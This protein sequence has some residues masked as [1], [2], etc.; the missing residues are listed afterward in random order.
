MRIEQ[1]EYVVAVTRHGSLRKAGERLHVSQPAL[2]EA[3][4][5]LERELGVVL[6]DRCRSGS[7]I[8]SQGRELLPTMVEVLE[9][10]ERLRRSAGDQTAR[11]R[12]L[13]VGTAGGATSTVLVPALKA[14][15][16]QHPGSGVEVLPVPQDEIRPALVD[17]GLDLGLVHA[18]HGDAV[19]ADLV[20]TDLLHGRAVVVLPAGHH[21]TAREAVTVAD[22]RHERT[23]LLGPGHP[24]HR[25]T[26]RLLGPDLP[27]ETH[28][29]EDAEV[30][31]LMV[32]DGLGVMLLPDYCVAGD[33]LHASGALTERP[34]VDA[35]TAVTLVAQHRPHPSQRVR[36]LLG[37]LGT[38]AA[39]QGWDRTSAPGRAALAR[40]APA[41]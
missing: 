17:H 28:G 27:R 24:M 2:S 41:G 33:P 6:L 10:V 38:Y 39:A 37:H 15:G 40:T 26:H 34:V 14:L 12:A 36:D 8:S 30:G 16:E 1:L 20:S 32:A 7:R 9:S 31:K 25:L 35:R 19:P 13:R 21:L 4:G 23:V 11:G 18:L 3:V 5:K 29:T 22:L